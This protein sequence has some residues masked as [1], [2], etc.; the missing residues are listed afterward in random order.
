MSL[1][2]DTMTHFGEKP[3]QKFGHFFYLQ[4]SEVLHDLIS[5]V[6]SFNYLTVN[7]IQLLKAIYNVNAEFTCVEQI[8]RYLTQSRDG[9]NKLIVKLVEM[10]LLNEIDFE[11]SCGKAIARTKCFTLLQQDQFVILFSTLEHEKKS[12]AINKTKIQFTSAKNNALSQHNLPPEIIENKV[13]KGFVLSQLPPFERMLPDR[14][15]KDNNYISNIYIKQK[16]VIVEAKSTQQIMNGD[17]LKTLYTLMTL[18]INQQANLLE[19]YAQKGC[20]PL[21]HHYIEIR[22]IMK[23]LGKNSAGSYY[24]SFVKSILRIKETSFDLHQLE[25]MYEDSEGENIFVSQDFRFFESCQAIAKENAEIETHENQQKSI[26]IKPFAFMITWNATLFEKMLTDKY[27]F[28]IPLKI[29]AAPTVIFLF[30]MILRTHFSFDRNKTWVLTLEELHNKLNSSALL[31]NFKRDFLTGLNNWNENKMKLPSDGKS[32]IDIQGFMITIHIIN[33]AIVK[34]HCKLDTQKMLSYAGLQSD[35]NGLTQQGV[36]AAPTVANPLQD[37][38][39]ILQFKDNRGNEFPQQSNMR[40]LLNSKQL[41]KDITINK[42]GKTTLTV[43]KNK[44]NKR[45]TAYSDDSVLL[46]ICE[47]VHKNQEDQAAFFTHLQTLRNKLSLLTVGKGNNQKELTPLLFSNILDSLVKQHD[48]II[49]IEELFDL[50]NG[51]SQ[52]IKI[53][54]DWDGNVKAPIIRK[55]AEMA[56]NISLYTPS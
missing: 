23:V 32:L 53:T 12:K 9:I 24:D 26:K 56:Q 13:N 36:Q 2:I 33:D 45:L 14:N 35:I 42:S 43:C 28:V 29:L 41:L 25:A 7:Q 19:Y 54:A 22:H 38:L 37:L 48:L 31:H 21:N 10:G 55:I 4:S 47:S 34:L 40:L 50:L 20:A 3:S 15:H 8:Q 5:K 30:Y 44:F 52:L 11:F 16:Q 18:S 39:P 17:D 1:I 49:E 27:F 51:K 6:E 46:Y